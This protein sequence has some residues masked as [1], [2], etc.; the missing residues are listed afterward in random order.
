[1][2]EPIFCRSATRLAAD[3]RDGT[4]SPEEVVESFLDRIEERDARTNSFTTVTAERARAGAQQSG[5]A[6]I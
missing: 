4:Y 2:T 5:D 6:R 3:I 1:M